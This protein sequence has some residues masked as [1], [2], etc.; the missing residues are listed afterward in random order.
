MKRFS[1][2]TEQVHFLRNLLVS[3][4]DNRIY[5]IECRIKK[6]RPVINANM[7]DIVQAIKILRDLEEDQEKLDLIHQI[8]NE[9]CDEDDNPVSG[10]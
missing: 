1:L 8:L 7:P 2:N 6:L 9:I 10:L 3:E 5:E 4:N